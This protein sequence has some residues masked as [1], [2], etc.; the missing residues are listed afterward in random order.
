VENQQVTGDYHHKKKT[1]NLQKILKKPLKTRKKYL[2]TPSPA[3][4][5][6]E[7]NCHFMSLLLNAA[8]F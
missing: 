7:I 3:R 5:F 4:P 8:T 6:R 1:K 2:K